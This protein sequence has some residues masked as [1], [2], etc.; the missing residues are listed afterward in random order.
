MRMDFYYRI[1]SGA[2]IVLPPLRDCPD[3]IRKICDLFSIDN[4]VVISEKLIEFYQSLPWPGNIRQLAG[5]LKR[6]KVFTKTR[7]FGF[8]K[9]DSELMQKSS[10]LYSINDEVEN[11]T[12]EELKSKYAKKIYDLCNRNATRAAMKLNISTKVLRRLILDDSA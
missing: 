2:C 5:Y 12:M 7:K 8:D 3:K 4:D 1:A 9:Y 10:E 6:K 11:L